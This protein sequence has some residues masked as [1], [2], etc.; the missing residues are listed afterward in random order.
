[1]DVAHRYRGRDRERFLGQLSLAP[2]EPEQLAKAIVVGSH[3][4]QNERARLSAA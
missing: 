4:P 2:Q 1:V 3:R